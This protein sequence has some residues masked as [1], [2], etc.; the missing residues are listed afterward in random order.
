MSTGALD[1]IDMDGTV[2]SEVRR[3]SDSPRTAPLTGRNTWVEG[4]CR[5]LDVAVALLV[6]LVLSP[7]MI[8]IAVLIRL[9]SPGPA[10]FSQERV[11]RFQRRFTLH[12]FRTMAA[13]ASHERHRE[14]VQGLYAGARPTATDR[15]PRFKMAADPR[16]TRVGRFLRRSSLDELPQL[17]NVVRGDMSLVGPRPPLQYEV[18]QYESW[19]RRRVIEAK[20]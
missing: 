18:E 20:P 2:P 1:P 10:I 12:K 15:G 19:H 3:E 4:S 11:G 8:V 17:W 7:L 13:G 5:V 14:F 6:L 16:I 9:E